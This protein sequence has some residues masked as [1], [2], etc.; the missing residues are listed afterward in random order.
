MPSEMDGWSLSSFIFSS[1]QSPCRVQLCPELSC[2]GRLCT[3]SREEE[4]ENVMPAVIGEGGLPWLH[5][6]LCDGYLSDYC[7]C[8]H[9]IYLFIIWRSEDSMW[10]QVLSSCLVGPRDGTQVPS[11]AEMSHHVSPL[12]FF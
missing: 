9:N 3:Y 5:T 12:N 2:S 1:L 11:P 7:S 8:K 4:N 10:E 6:L